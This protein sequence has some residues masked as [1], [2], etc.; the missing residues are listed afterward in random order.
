MKKLLCVVA[1]FALVVGIAR[2]QD[3]AGQWQGTLQAGGRSLRIVIRVASAAGSGLTAVLYSI[4]QGAQPLAA[5]GVSLEAGTFKFVIPVLNASYEGR[6]SADGNSIAGT[7]A[8]GGAPNPL[9]LSRASGD[10]AWALPAPPAAA[11]P[12]PPD[13]RPVFDVATIKPSDPNRGPGKLFTMRGRQVMT[14]NTS[15]NDLITFAYGLHPKQIGER[16]SWVDSDRYDVTGQ[17]DIEGAPNLVQFRHLIEKLLADR[18]KLT[19]HRETRELAVYALV[20]GSKGPTL[21]KSAAQGAL[22]SLLFRGL[23][24]L[25]AGNATMTDFTDTLQSAV[26]DRPVLNRT[27]LEGRYDFMLRWT[28]DQSQFMSIGAQVPPPPADGSGPPELFTAI[29]EQLGLKL[30]STRGPVDVIVVDRVERPTE[31]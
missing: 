17:P 20:V 27:G 11:R 7:F 1:L 2:A 22:P 30:E 25:P 15:V 19:I 29:Q 12:M 16:P 9:T 3:I 6:L 14:L 21:T 5:N 10:A 24:V 13:A 23:G 31:N 18:F 8:Q 28:P 26:L 4:D